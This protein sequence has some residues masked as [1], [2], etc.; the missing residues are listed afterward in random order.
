[1]KKKHFKSESKRLMDLMINSIYTHKEIFLREIIS[2]SSDALDKLYFKSLTDT[3]VGLS[4]DEFVIDI[5]LDKDNRTITVSDNGIGMTE[6]ELDSNLGTIAKSGSFAFKDE[7]EKTDDIDIIGQFGVGF[8]SAFMVSDKVTVIT[9]AYGSDKAYKWESEGVDGYRIGECEKDSFGTSVI[10][11]LKPDTEDDDYCKYLDEYTI[12]SLVKKYSDYIRHPIRMEMTRTVLKEGAEDE[13]EDVTELTVLNSRIPIWKKSKSEVTDEEYNEFYKEKFYDFEDPIKVIRSSVEGSATYTSLL[14]IPTHAPYNYYSK[15]YEKGLSLYSKGVLIMDKC[16][17]L[18]PDYFSFVKGLVDSEDLSL[19]ISREML[20]HDSQLRLISKTVEKKIRTELEKML[21]DERENYEKFFESF[22]VQLKFGV[23]NDFGMHKDDLKDLL[24]FKSSYE[25]K[26]V[27]LKEYVERL[28]EDDKFIYYATG[29]TAEK[30]EMLPQYDSAVSKGLE[31]LMLTEYVDE[32]VIKTL[33]EYEGKTFVNVCD[34]NF[35][36]STDEEKKAI[37]KENEDN[38]ELLGKIKD[39]L[40]GKVNDVRFTNKL[41]GH[42]VCLT[43]EGEISL[44]MEKTIN[45]LPGAQGN[46]VKATV[47]L[48]INVE[49][50]VAQ[51]LKDIYADAPDELEKYAKLLYGEACLIAGRSID[52]PVEHSK[53][54]CEFMS[55]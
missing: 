19:N 52:D 3:S 46:K 6:E 32:F 2:N 12:Q 34:E 54:V 14:F 8:Y 49:H 44:D 20:Q 4:A 47:A 9:K 41:S 53:L 22:G 50:P 37:E 27:T 36:L 35:D 24:L 21:R 11:H 48:D 1:M 38:S 31:V 17:D 5:D 39:S 29:E 42:P 13:Y 16:P 10:M 7:S 40:G 18:L 26:P 23:Y 55:K 15:D 45:S 43:S 25:K 30:I 33:M 51:K 28:K